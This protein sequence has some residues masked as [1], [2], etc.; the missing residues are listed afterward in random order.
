[1]FEGDTI[2]GEEISKDISGKDFMEGYYFSGM[3]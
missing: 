2:I 3:G 1:M